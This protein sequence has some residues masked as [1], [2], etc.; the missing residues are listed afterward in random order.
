MSDLIVK[1]AK[2]NAM[3]RDKIKSQHSNS[4]PFVLPSRDLK[5]KLSSVTR[6]TKTGI[7]TQATPAVPNSKPATRPRLTSF[8][9]TSTSSDLDLDEISHG[10]YP[11]NPLQV[12]MTSEVSVHVERRGS[13]EDS[14]KNGSGRLSSLGE[15]DTRPLRKEESK[16]ASRDG[17]TRSRGEKRMGV[18]TDVYV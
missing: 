10:K 5:S 14:A 3:A 11:R 4:N 7:I 9:S 6:D 18:S 2:T 1:V 15:D 12:N 16:R 17:G 8:N 13:E